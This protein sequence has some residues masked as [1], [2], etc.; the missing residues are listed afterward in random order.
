LAQKR[1]AGRDHEKQQIWRIERTEDMPDSRDPAANIL[2]PA[3]PPAQLGEHPDGRP[4][5]ANTSQVGR[6]N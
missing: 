5:R 3:R 4:N 2:I 6:R 1:W